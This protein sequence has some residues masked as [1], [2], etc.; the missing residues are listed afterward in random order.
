ML[1]NTGQHPCAGFMDIIESN[2]GTANYHG[3][4]FMKNSVALRR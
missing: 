3:R 4:R 1:V 2:Q